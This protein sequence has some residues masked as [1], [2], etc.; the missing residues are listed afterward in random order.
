MDSAKVELLADVLARC[1][2]ARI[3]VTGSSML[4]A[5]WPGDEL[6]VRDAAIDRV[7]CGDIVLFT[8]GH[9]LF[10]HRVVAAAADH[11]VTRGDG[12]PY[13]D[14]PVDAGSLMGVVVSAWRAGTR[15]A[16]SPSTRP[17]SRIVAGLVRRSSRASKMFQLVY[18]VHQRLRF[19]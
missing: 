13:P 14:P 3:R 18:A 2:E 6:T 8:R 9:R 16:L 1:G 15:A 10:A 19:A 17:M 11:L 12:L 5:L 7:R 4:P